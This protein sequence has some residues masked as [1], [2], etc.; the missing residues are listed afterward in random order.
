MTRFHEVMRNVIIGKRKP[1]A[2]YNRIFVVSAYGGITD[3][4]LDS[5]KTGEP[6]VFARFAGGHQD[7]NAKLDSVRERMYVLNRSFA[8][9]G[10]DL[11]KADAFV[12]ERIEGVRTCLQDLSPSGT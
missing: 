1:E 7:W 9:I 8:D 6:G 2:M 11:N 4:L 12:D 5:K 10:L 3:M